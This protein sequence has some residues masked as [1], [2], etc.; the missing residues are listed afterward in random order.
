M[1]PVLKWSITSRTTLKNGL[2]E[3]DALERL[4]DVQGREGEQCKPDQ[5]GQGIGK[6]FTLG[7][8][9]T[10]LYPTS[11]PR[12]LLIDEIDKADLDLPNDLLNIFEDGRFSIPELERYEEQSV[13]SVNAI[14]TFKGH[15]L[16]IE[17]GHVQCTQFPFVVLT[18]NG[19]REFPAP[20][21]RRC[22]RARI[23]DP[24][25]SQL[26]EIVQAH[27]GIEL[28]NAVQA[29]ISEFARDRGK[30]ATDQL[31]NTVYMTAGVN[32]P[33]SLE[34]ITKLRELLMKHLQ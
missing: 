33:E 7:P 17:R 27:L 10:A 34:E 19:E 1:G 20:F 13:V 32:K 21:L 28:R 31:L 9:G 3:Y 6:Y 4:R 2:Y 5:G 23:D 11:W 30:L 22:I 14:S 16:D 12:A 29:L 18:S 8:L 15:K 24:S 26:G 25:E